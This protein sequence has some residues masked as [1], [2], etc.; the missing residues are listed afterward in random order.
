[1]AEY[2]K[3]KFIK[4]GVVHVKGEEI[5]YVATSEDFP[6]KD[7]FGNVEASIFTF[8]YERADV[9]DK[10]SRPVMFCYN[11]GPGSCSIYINLGFCAP[12][13]LK[14][15]DDVN[16]MPKVGPF[17][18]E[19]NTDCVI[20]VVDMVVVDAIGTGYSRL[21][22]PE[23][24][25][26]YLSSTEGDVAAFAKLISAW[27][28]AHDRWDSPIYLYGESYG[29][30]RNAV[31]ADHLFSIGGSEG[32]ASPGLHVAGVIML[33]TALNH[34]TVELPFPRSCA[35][36][37]PYAAVNWYY[38]PEGKGTLEDF[39]EEC[40]QFAVTD[41]VSALAQGSWLPDEQKRKIA[42]RLNYFTGLPVDELL[43]RDNVI[44]A[45]SYTVEGFAK[46]NMAVGVYDGRLNLSTKDA[47]RDPP[48]MA[49]VSNT[50][51]SNAVMSAMFVGAFNGTM[52]KFLNIETDEDYRK[53][54]NVHEGWNFN[55]K[56]SPMA[57]LE[58][59][60]LRNEKLKLMFCAG[61]Y[62]LLTT[63]GNVRYIAS[64]YKYPAD[65][66]TMQYYESGHMPYLGLSSLK[67]MAD[68]VREFILK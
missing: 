9:K 34:G 3:K 22:E 18:M 56:I 27:L 25:K 24:K 52:K 65:R 8:T 64:H 62:D 4:E 38:H 53:T 1:M 60:M 26:K 23:A 37:E 41:Y 31:L 58:N 10:R 33:G 7:E 47:R 30:P 42:E 20:D 11:G 17:P 68:D 48:H 19:E 6:I 12:L 46:E 5:P 45:F 13:R 43:A 40:Y 67:K 55:C 59:A 36:I 54:A 32:Y 15:G 44:E 63:V 14:T 51:A 16:S 57:S 2:L 61:Y 28:T 50:D 39:V 49:F 21:L 35:N 66:T 29:T